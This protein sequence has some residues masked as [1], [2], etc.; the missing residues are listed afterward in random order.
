MRK[1][2][3]IILAL[4]RCLSLMACSSDET[5]MGTTAPSQAQQSTKPS[6]DSATQET[7][8]TT[9]RHNRNRICATGAAKFPWEISRP[10]VP[11]V[12]V[13][14]AISYENPVA[15]ICIVA[16]ITAT[17]AAASTPPL[18]TVSTAPSIN[19][20]DPIATTAD[21]PVPNTAHTT[22]NNRHL[23]ASLHR[24]GDFVTEII[25]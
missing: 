11:T 5:I 22:N 3:A 13:S 1:L 8:K 4:V 15:T 17:R 23:F 14:N 21:G 18:K 24:G 2:L 7:K 25:V 20:A 12:V 9:N 19:A 10:I 6:A 16:T